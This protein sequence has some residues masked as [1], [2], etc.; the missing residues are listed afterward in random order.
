MIAI[1]ESL[2]KFLVYHRTRIEYLNGSIARL[3]DDMQASK[4]VLVS[5]K[6]AHEIIV[7]NIENS[8]AQ[9]CEGIDNDN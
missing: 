7:C 6:I 3:P 1:L 5:A 9:L 4:D 8:I 2:E